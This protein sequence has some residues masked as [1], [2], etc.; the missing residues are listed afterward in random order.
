MASGGVYVLCINYLHV[1]QVRVTVGD[2]GLCCCNLSWAGDATSIIFVMTNHI[3]CCDK[4]MLVMTNIF[5]WW[6]DIFCHDKACCDKYFLQQKCACHDKHIFVVTKHILPWQSM[7]WQ[8]FVATN[9]LLQQKYFIATNTILWQKS[10]KNDNYCPAN[11]S[12]CVM[13]FEC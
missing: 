2:S 5:L 8:I 1:C 3:F 9:F 7:L 12:N 6:Q 13:Y 11:D 4:S 10:Y